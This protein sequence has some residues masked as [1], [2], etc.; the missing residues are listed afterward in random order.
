LFKQRSGVLPTLNNLSGPSSGNNRP[1][2]SNFGGD[3]DDEDDDDGLGAFSVSNRSSAASQP[4]LRYGANS[5]SNNNQRSYGNSRSFGGE[6]EDNSVASENLS[7][8]GD[9]SGEE[10]FSMND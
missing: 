3:D 10:S 5:Y 4:N 8:G 2:F 7:I 9:N 1:T 6:S